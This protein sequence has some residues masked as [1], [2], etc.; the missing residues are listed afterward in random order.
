MAA[1]DWTR[2]GEAVALGWTLLHFCWQGTVV[3]LLY[4][5]IDRLTSA[6][7]VRVRYV[8]A[9]IA[10]ALMPSL[11]AA[12]FWEQSHLVRSITFD[13]QQRMAS[14]LSEMHG[15]LLTQIPMTRSVV[16]TTELWLAGNADRVLPCIDGIWVGGV[17][18]MAVRALGGWW[19]LEYIRKQA[20]A[21]VPPEVK[22]LFLQ[23]KSQL[24]ISRR[25]VL[26]ISHDV[27]SPLA[28][29]VWRTTILLPV[30]AALQ[31]TPA[32]LEAVLAHE[33]A[34]VRR[35]DYL[36]NLVQTGVECV[37]FFHPAVWWISH[38][39][40]ELREVCCD[41]VAAR[42]CSDPVI[43][44]EA[45]LQLEQERCERFV[46]ATTLH[47]NGGPLL[48]RVSHIL[49][50][51]LVMKRET[52]GSI[53]VGVASAVL[54]AL[55]I[56]PKVANGLRV[57]SHASKV[58]V[59]SSETISEP[60]AEPSRQQSRVSAAPAT[61]AEPAQ[62]AKES[63]ISSVEAPAPIVS[64]TP[65]PAPVP[66]PSPSP[67]PAPM[68]VATP[69]GDGQEGRQSG[70][71]DYIQKMRDA[72][73]ALDLNKDL[74]TLISMRSV[75]VTPEYAKAMA[76]VGLGTPTPRDLISLKAVGVTPEYVAELRGSGIP[77]TNF[78]EAISERSMGIT[79]E[80][81]KSISAMG[82]GSP[83]VHDLVGLKAQGITQEYLASLRAS[84]INPK[85]LHELTSLKAV[86]V[87][88]E[89]AKAM[90]DTGYPNLSTHELVSL[91]AQGVTPEYAR[92]LK[93]TFHDAD[94]HNLHQASALHV[95]ADF[96]AKAKAHGFEN[97]SLDKLVKLKLTGL[98]D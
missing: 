23:V 32:Q 53:R 24:G 67:A 16:E 33:L 51:K 50:E 5:G 21:I 30:S 6:A 45:L 96:V 98:L 90:T 79:P 36:F 19:R 91:R 83:T 70:G 86:G 9:V 89:F 46:L 1:M 14:G 15:V 29:G 37:L 56:G 35:W 10:L 54:L 84:G 22:A 61:P 8:L 57:S 55:L 18:L 58:G 2:N 71:A 52:T 48:G 60:V 77:P 92:W 82:M 13:G 94:T 31:L 26:R 17:F 49:G 66:A 25:L 40:R 97:A 65:A 39:T 11:V 59:V 85:D 20:R 63:V 28:M 4:A 72:G 87:T 43:Y 64:A 78:H 44:V 76:G 34:H 74:D 47:G 3:A 73:Y 88:P 7:S 93:Q 69:F 38:R 81:A 68:P 95:D 75:G 42:S 27:I 12:T 62:P 41:D 80:Y